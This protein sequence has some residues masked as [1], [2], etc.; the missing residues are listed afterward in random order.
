MHEP[1]FLPNQPTREARRHRLQPGNTIAIEP[2]L[3]AGTSRYRTKS[4]DWSIAAAAAAAG[5]HAA[6]AEHTNRRRRRRPGGPHQLMAP[7]ADHPG[8]PRTATHAEPAITMSHHS[9]PRRRN[10]YREPRRSAGVR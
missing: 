1:P 4:D 6:H 3:H 8:P 7:T 9:P 5:K 2:M 10:V